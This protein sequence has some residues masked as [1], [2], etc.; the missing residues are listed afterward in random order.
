MPVLPSPAVPAL[1]F[2]RPCSCSCLPRVRS[3]SRA[4]APAS[5]RSR[6]LRSTRPPA[7]ALP[8]PASNYSGFAFCA[9]FRGI[10]VRVRCPGLPRRSVLLR[11]PARGAARIPVGRNVS[12]ETSVRVGGG[13]GWDPCR[14]A[15]C[16]GSFPCAWKRTRAMHDSSPSPFLPT[17]G[18]P[19]LLRRQAPI[20]VHSVRSLP[21]CFPA[22]C[23]RCRR[24]PVQAERGGRRPLGW[25]PP[26]LARP[27]R[28]PP[29]LARGF[30]ILI[31]GRRSVPA[32]LVGAARIPVSRDVSRET[33]VR[34]LSPKTLLTWSPLEAL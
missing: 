5:S 8:T 28:P 23:G 30:P 31:L 21:P 25:R 13:A 27:L 14:R 16:D 12:R 11:R 33:S 6:T 2:S 17:W 3:R 32:R 26:R 4:P 34:I 24:E 18:F 15:P 1:R 19:P 9:R 20:I 10:C 22:F 7:S 29:G